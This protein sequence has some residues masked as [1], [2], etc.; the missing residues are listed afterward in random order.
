MYNI[1]SIYSS[2]TILT[3]LNIINDYVI[4][5]VVNIALYVFIVR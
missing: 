1:V 5:L 4:I 2:I 3:I